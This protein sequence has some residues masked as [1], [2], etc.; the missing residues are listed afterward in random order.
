MSTGTKSGKQATKG[1]KQIAEENVSTLKFY[2][3]MAVIAAAVYFSTCVLWWSTTTTGDLVL[4]SI[5]AI[6]N[7]GF[8]QFMVYMARPRYSET[9]QLLD[10]GVDLN[11]E[12][13]VAEH[14]KDLI[15]LTSGIQS[16]ASISRYFWLLGLVAPLRFGHMGWKHIISPWLFQPAQPEEKDDKKQRKMERKVRRMQH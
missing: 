8:Y 12:S 11:L 9:G 1:S 7:T 16:L 5:A 13:G 6:L 2:R 10:C 15:I 3:N 4:F 14:V